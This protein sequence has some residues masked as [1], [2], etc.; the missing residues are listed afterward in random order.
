MRSTKKKKKKK[1]P[2]GLGRK[3][4]LVLCII[5]FVG[6]AGVLLDYVINGM[7]EESA[8]NDLANMKM[9]GEELVT[10]KGTVVAEYSKLYQANNDIIGWIKI[11]GTK[12]DYPVMQTQD[13]PE[14]YIR[15]GFDK[16][17]TSS[18]T[19][20][21]DAASDIFIPTSNFMIY[22]HNM[23]NGTMFHD[24]LKYESK[25]FYKEH[26][27]IKFD[28]IYKG[29]QGT[30]EVIA[31]GYTQIYPKDSDKFKY[32][33]YAGITTESEFN[34]FIRGVRSLTPYKMDG[35]AEYGD[36]LITLSTCAYHVD[37]G[38]FFVVAKR[39]DA[40]QVKPQ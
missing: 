25:D 32:Y 16:E 15:R 20:F 3:I 40:K 7:R 21:M 1:N 30:Y 9:S 18:G 12:V 34:E 10:D 29:G 17:S 14:Y 13:D 39:V 27:K 11:N 22:G 38:R 8:L 19:P 35:T 33:Q 4:I 28:T 37:E 31:A 6:S 24:I 5:V 23:K 36:Q 26:K 2:V